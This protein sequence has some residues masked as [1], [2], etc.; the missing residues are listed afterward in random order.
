MNESFDFL[1]FALQ[2]FCQKIEIEIRM[3][4]LK[5][6]IYKMYKNKYTFIYKQLFIFKSIK[7][8]KK[9]QNIKLLLNIFKIYVLNIFAHTCIYFCI[10][11]FVKSNLQKLICSK[12]RHCINYRISIKRIEVY[13][14]T[15]KREDQSN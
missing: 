14:Q 4:Y 15:R 1:H 7:N 5:S 9:Y 13:I 6:K 3:F 11:S 12:G 2:Y 10:E 8:I